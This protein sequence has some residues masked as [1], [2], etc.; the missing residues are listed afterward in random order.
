M[1]QNTFLRFN[2]ILVSDKEIRKTWNSSEMMKRKDDLYKYGIFV[3]HDSNPP[4]AC[5]GSCIFIHIWEGFG[6]PTS[7]C[8]SMSEE[9][10]IKVLHWINV[11]K[12]PLLIQMPQ[13]E[14]DKIKNLLPLSS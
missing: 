5:C 7:G 13:K 14:F 9:N 8:T 1:T 6:K 2:N 12:K 11:K 4:K 10:L 3:E